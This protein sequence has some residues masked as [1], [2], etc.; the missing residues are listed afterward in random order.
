MLLLCPEEVKQPELKYSFMI[1]ELLLLYDE[2]L[3]LTLFEGYVNYI[4]EKLIYPK[5]EERFIPLPE[6]I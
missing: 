6:N 2:Q 1:I 3:A 4:E 5:T